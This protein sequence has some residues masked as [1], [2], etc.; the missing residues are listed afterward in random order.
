M[1][2]TQFQPGVRQGVAE[3][4]YK[5]IGAE[6]ISKDGY[7]ERKINDDMPRQARW[8]AVH[9]VEWEAVHGRVP[10]GYALTFQNGDKRDI[11][12]DNLVLVSRADLMR[13]NTIHHLPAPLVE[14]IQLLGR[15]KRRIQRSE[16]AQEQ[17]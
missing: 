8:R 17:D 7:R 16:H 1:R 9:L 15:L 11:R 4:L 2:D 14:T 10:K 12:L 3:R 6:R 5:P 13:R